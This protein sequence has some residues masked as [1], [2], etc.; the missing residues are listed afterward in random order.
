LGGGTF[1]VSILKLSKGVF[2]VLS[3]GGDSALGGDD[4]DH[5]VFCWI[6]E[7]ANLAPLSDE[8]TRTLMVKAREAKEILSTHEQT[9]ID[10]VLNSGEEVRLTITDADFVA[11]TQHLVNKTVTPCRKAVRD[12]EL[13]I[14]DIDGVVLVGGATRMPHVR[15]AVADYF[16][17]LPLA[18][19]DPDKVVALGAAIQANL[20]AGNRASGDDWLLDE[21]VTSIMGESS[22]CAMLLVLTMPILAGD[23]EDGV[24]GDSPRTTTFLLI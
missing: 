2:E 23:G 17:T 3:T 15:K 7:Q 18:N 20:L 8:D 19:I 16:K 9:H 22:G 5:R 21:G 10:A 12:A 6:I 14:D 13:N 4:F 24:S 11:L 1:D